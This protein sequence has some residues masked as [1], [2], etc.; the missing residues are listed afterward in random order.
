MPIFQ[1]LRCHTVSSVPS[2]SDLGLLTYLL[3]Y[4]LAVVGDKS[5]IPNLGWPELSTSCL[6]LSGW[7]H[8]Y[9][10]PSL[11][12]DFFNGYL[13][14]ELEVPYPKPS[15]AVDTGQGLGRQQPLVPSS[16]A[17]WHSSNFA[18]GRC[19]LKVEMPRMQE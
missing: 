8:P 4:L 10:T 11:K 12:A 16:P 2:P 13:T 19:T 15:K 17:L 7:D 14:H 18:L 1:K 6:G 9:H 5:L 3:T